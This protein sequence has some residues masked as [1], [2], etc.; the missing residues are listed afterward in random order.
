MMYDQRKT[1]GG[2]SADIVKQDLGLRGEKILMLI[3]LGSNGVIAHATPDD[4]TAERVH[5]SVPDAF[6]SIDPSDILARVNIE[7]VVGR[8]KAYCLVYKDRAADIITAAVCY[9]GPAGHADLIVRPR[10]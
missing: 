3:A 7:D 5:L 4:V 2:T 1:L 10:K 9:E 6:D 8:T